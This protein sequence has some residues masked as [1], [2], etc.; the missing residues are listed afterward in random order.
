M[1]LLKRAALGKKH[2]YFYEREIESQPMGPSDILLPWRKVLKYGFWAEFVLLVFFTSLVSNCFG[3]LFE[4]TGYY[5]PKQS[6]IFHFKSGRMNQGSG[7]WW[8]DGY[9]HRYFYIIGD[10]P[11]YNYISVHNT[12][13]GFDRHARETWCDDQM[14]WSPSPLSV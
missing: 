8:L 5:I 1:Q 7:E 2:L 6:S 4:N 3:F 13:K 12:C 9:D 11:G 14:K 10:G